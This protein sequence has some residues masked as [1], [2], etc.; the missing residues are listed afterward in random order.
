MD[1]PPNL[2]AHYNRHAFCG[3]ALTLNTCPPNTYQKDPK[4]IQAPPSVESYSRQSACLSSLDVACRPNSRVA[5]CHA[6]PQALGNR[7]AFACNPPIARTFLPIASPR[8][9]KG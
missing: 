3:I 9:P 8:A 7:Y 1:F 2:E 4:R 6:I 5:D